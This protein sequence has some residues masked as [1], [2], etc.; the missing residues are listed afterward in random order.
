MK[1]HRLK[2]QLPADVISEDAEI[3]APRLTDWR[4]LYHGAALALARPHTKEEVA[5]ILQWANRTKTPI[6]PQ[7]GNT[8]LAGAATPDASGKA[9]LLSLE[10]M[11]KIRWLSAEDNALIAEAGCILHHI[12]EAAARIDRLFPLSLASE[13][14]AQL[15]G[16]LATNAGG[17]NVL[18]YGMMRDLTLGLEIV[19]ADGSILSHLSAL[20]KDNS[21]YDWKQIFIGSE[22]T[23]GIIT[24]ACLKL[25]PNPKSRGTAFLALRSLKD[26]PLLYHLC[27]DFL[28]EKL[29]AFELIPDRGLKLANAMPP[30]VDRYEWYVLVEVAGLE[31]PPLQ[32]AMIEALKKEWI[33]DGAIAQNITQAKKFWSLREAMVEAQSHAAFILRHDIALPI[34]QIPAFVEKAGEMVRLQEENI[35]ILAFGHLGD[36]NIHFNLLAKH[37]PNAALSLA[38]HDLVMAMGGS[39]SAEHGIGQ[40]RL[41]EMARYKSPEELRLMRTLKQSLDPN[42]ILNP[43]KILPCQ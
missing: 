15:G 25:F 3:L 19:L 27:Q 18:R 36:G 9:L 28:D 1:L 40:A 4:K 30:F 33:E 6:V 34:G 21:G 41:T 43:G 35:Q 16:N 32:Y 23:L 22:G 29:T 31:N 39:F 17:M 14:T 11:H 26:A 42:C 24:A 2:A 8:G 12:Q 10:R 5:T 37:A 20:R 13:G 38:L 7:G